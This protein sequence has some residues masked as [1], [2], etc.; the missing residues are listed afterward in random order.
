MQILLALIFGGSYG[1]LLHYTMAGRAARGVALAPVV[2]AVLGGAT[3][4]L[5]TWLGF[6]IESPW[7]WL[8]AVAVPAV[9][10]PA[11][12]VILRRVRDA[13]DQRE[14]VRLGIA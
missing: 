5:L 14:R 7:I 13:H 3:W 8:A 1:A 10:M 4:L 12:L 9:A 11:L 2:G 6:T